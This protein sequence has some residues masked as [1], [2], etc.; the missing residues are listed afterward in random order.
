[1]N[2]TVESYTAPAEASGLLSP[3]ARRH[4]RRLARAVAPHAEALEIRFL[5][6]LRKR[7]FDAPQS[8][9]MAAISPVAASRLLLRRPVTTFLEQ[10][11]YNGRRLAKLNASPVGVAEALREFDRLLDL[12][13]GGCCQPAREQ[14]H[15][16]TGM[17]L[18]HAYYQVR[19]AEA[20]ALFG[21]YETE[22]ESPDVGATLR[23]YVRALARTFRARAGR[24][25]VLDEEPAPE[26]RGPL[27]IERGVGKA[28]LVLDADLWRRC[29]AWW[30]YPVHSG[31][32][33][34]GVMQFG[35]AGPYPWLPREET[36]LAA[37]AEQCR[38][39]MER[40]QLVRSLEE[41]ERAVRRLSAEARRAEEE[42]R[43]RLGRELHDETAQSMLL[44]RLQLEMLERDISPELRPRVAD[45]RE[46]VERNI[47]EL[48]RIVAA[49]SPVVLERMGL[50]AALRQVAARFRRT[51]PAELNLRISAPEGGLAPATEQVIY[52]VAQECLQNAARHSGASHVNLSLGMADRSVR[53]RVS[54]DGA[55][56]DADAVLRRGSTFGLAG[57][58]ER[59]ALLGGA[60][61]ISS[62]SGKGSTIQLRLPRDSAEVEHNGKDSR[63]GN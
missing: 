22:S 36:L 55:G 28:W 27:Y 50:K 46:T 11:E 33:T 37:A 3:E 7:G 41:S 26:L 44:V 14:L 9:A 59:A 20:Q 32:R 48:R 60:L 54:D 56:F 53:L 47:V 4:L 61:E 12:A 17:T 29:R 1:M 51:C 39:A 45:V 43:R 31:G 42:E 52:R 58:R 15:L 5:K 49:L 23:Q 16:A 13:L 18:N 19:E 25:S 34:I 10:A 24:M 57:M 62:Q 35:F 6:L 38:R 21:L 40:A 63:S 2:C 30:S 8:K